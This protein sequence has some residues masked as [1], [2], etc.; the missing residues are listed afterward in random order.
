M[1]AELIEIFE[2]FCSYLDAFD[3]EQ[4]TSYCL[5]LLEEKKVTIPKLYQSIFAQSLNRI[6]VPRGSA[7]EL[8]WREH[9]Q[10]NIVRGIVE[11]AYPFVL[12]ERDDY[13]SKGTPGRILLACP[14][15]EYHE[16]G[17]RMGA[18]FYTI[19]GFDVHFIGSNLPRSSMISAVQ[20]L[21]PDYVGISVTNY[22]RLVQLKRIV[23][24][25]REKIGT[26]IK[27]VVSGSAF[28]HTGS[29]A[30][31]FGADELI[32]TFE[33]VVALAGRSYETRA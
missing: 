6:E 2:R 9:A 7:D 23:E 29:S 20:E 28:N 12:H 27:I 17:I 4:A 21:N 11:S 13:Q 1:N 22:L 32:N 10:T 18:D 16:L 26:S 24:S 5:R 33:D 14:E 15:E 25:L 31:D 19:A 8:I 30:Q 3:K